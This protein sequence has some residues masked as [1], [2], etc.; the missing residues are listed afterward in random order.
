MFDEQDKAAPALR[1]AALPARPSRAGRGGGAARVRGRRFHAGVWYELRPAENGVFYIHWSEGRR[2]RRESTREKAIAPATAY[3][4]EWLTL[5]D[6]PG[7]GQ[8]L[9]CADLWQRKYGTSERHGYLWRHLEPTFGPLRPADVTQDTID[10]YVAG[11]DAAP[12]TI[13]LEV[14]CLVA[15][16]NA[17][18]KERHLTSDDVP[19]ITPPEDS[20][21]RDRWLNDAE[22]DRLLAA[23]EGPG[24]M[25][26]AERF[27]YLALDTGA[28]RTAIQELRWDTGQVDFA[29]G[30]IDFLPPGRKQMSNKRRAAVP[31]SD[32]LRAVLLRAYEER[33]GPYVLDS[34]ANVNTA[35]TTLARN[36]GLARVTPH[37]LRHTAATH[38]ARRGVPLWIVAKLLGD[39]LATVE[40]VY[41]KWQPD[42]GREAVE[43][44]GGA[45]GR[46]MGASAQDGH[47]T[48]PTMVDTSLE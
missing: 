22:I 25:G 36:A 23:A 18:V 3:F 16:W 11:R 10:R 27:V 19:A 28:R 32:R 42:F 40:A 8:V 12:A 4:D 30:A 2:S 33:V 13:R 1:P 29:T 9:T 7:R 47:Q 14:V 31:M 24:R 26:R 6:A 39:S 37:V 5:L 41:A 34:P 48:R 43:T 35:L 20:P 46:E 44:I 15:A 38:M 21:P 17:A 45:W